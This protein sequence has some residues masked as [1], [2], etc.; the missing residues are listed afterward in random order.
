MPLARLSIPFFL[1]VLL[2]L[3]LSSV[4]ALFG[5]VQWAW[6]KQSEQRW[7]RQS[8]QSTGVSLSESEWQAAHN[9]LQKALWFSPGHPD[10]LQ[11][12]GRLSSWSYWLVDPV[13]HDDQVSISE[14]GIDSL[15]QSL[16]ARPYW[17]YAWSEL[18]LLK[19]QSGQMDASMWQALQA[20]NETG[21]WERQALLNRLNA[22]IGSWNQLSV[23]Q[24]RQLLAWI[25]DSLIG[26]NRTDFSR[27]VVSML[28]RQGLKRGV[29]QS[30][31]DWAKSESKMPAHVNTA[32]R[33]K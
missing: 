14:Q 13:D 9:S 19:A 20:S 3:A 15:Q 2:T 27:Q 24:R 31:D 11:A 12:L 30:F 29:C 17:S 5:D 28:D 25:G 6:A 23:E 26:V 33:G 18:A 7:Q 21:P 8:Q 22:G 32:C 4:S 10:Y 16:Q 1:L